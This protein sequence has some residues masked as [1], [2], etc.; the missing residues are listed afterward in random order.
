MSPAC[1]ALPCVEY[2]GCLLGECDG[3]LGM[4]L[5]P[6][7]GINHVARPCRRSRSCQRIAAIDDRLA[8][9][10]NAIVT[11][12]ASM[13]RP[14]VSFL[15]SVSSTARNRIVSSG[16]NLR[17]R[18]NFAVSLYVG[19]GI[20]KAAARCSTNRRDKHCNFVG[21]A[22]VLP[23]DF[24]VQLVRA[25]RPSSASGVDLSTVGTCR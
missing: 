24:A 7:A 10:S 22:L 12:T 8:P 15:R 11:N 21:R 18:G 16:V 20:V 5:R 4:I 3:Q 1:T 6:R 19:S 2:S 17:E 25:P 23:A 14:L 13:A 9:V